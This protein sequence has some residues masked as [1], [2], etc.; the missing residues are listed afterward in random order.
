[1]E[2]ALR[3]VAADLGDWSRNVL[4]DL[5]KR[6]KIL[7]ELWRSVGGGGFVKVEWQERKC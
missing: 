4:G 5:E 1:V 6:I 3:K 2:G 7:G